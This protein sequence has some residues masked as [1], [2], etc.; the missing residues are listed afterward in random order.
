MFICMKK[1]NFIPP[2]F[3]EIFQR[4][5]KLA[6]LDTLGMQAMTKSNTIS[7]YKTLIFIFMLKNIYLSF[8]L[9]ILQRYWK[10]C[11]LGYFGHARPCPSN[12]TSL[13]ET[14]VFICSKKSIWSLNF[15]EALHFKGYIPLLQ[16]YFLP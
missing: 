3:F 7:L 9:E 14:L 10:T 11:Y 1:F 16:N 2:F 4:Y 12:S 13:L 5:C 15:L 6:I 8:F